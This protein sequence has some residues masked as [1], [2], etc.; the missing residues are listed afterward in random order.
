MSNASCENLL[1]PQ[2]PGCFDA[3]PYDSVQGCYNF[4]PRD[5]NNTIEVVAC[6]TEKHRPNLNSTLR[7]TVLECHGGKWQTGSVTGVDCK[8]EPKSAWRVVNRQ[9][10]KRGWWVNELTFYS[11]NNC[12]K[13]F[14]RTDMAAVF[15][16]GPA[17]S[18]SKPPD[19]FDGN[20]ASFWTAPCVSADA[21]DVCGCA[22]YEGLGWSR[23]QQKC[24]LGVQTNGYSEA[25][26][27]ANIAAGNLTVD[28]ESRRGCPAGAAS[29]GAYFSSPRE[30]GCVR[31]MQ[32]DAAGFISDAVELQ[33]WSME[34]WQN[35]KR[36][37]QL[38]GNVWHDLKVAE[39][40]QP[41]ALGYQLWTEVAGVNGPGSEGDRRTVQ[42][43]G[44]YS[45]A[46]I[47]CLR[48]SWSEIPPLACL[49]PDVPADEGLS[50]EEESLLRTATSGTDS[51]FQLAFFVLGLVLSLITMMV[52]FHLVRWW[53]RR[54]AWLRLVRQGAPVPQDD[55]DMEFQGIAAGQ[56]QKQQSKEKAGKSGFNVRKAAVPSVV[57]KKQK[58][59]DQQEREQQRQREAR[60]ARPK[61]FPPATRGVG[62]P[63]APPSPADGKRPLGRET[64]R[65]DQ[66]LGSPI[67]S[68]SNAFMNS[69]ASNGFANGSASN[70]FA[71]GG[72][73][74]IK[75]G[76]AMG[77]PVA[78]PAS[79][80]QFSS[81]Q[82]SQSQ[83]SSPLR[84]Q[85]E[86]ARPA[87]GQQFSS[88]PQP[89]SR[90][91]MMGPASS[92]Y[93][94]GPNSRSESFPPSSS[95][96]FPQR[97]QPQTV[98]S[99]TP[100]RSASHN[101]SPPAATPSPARSAT[102]GFGNAVGGTPAAMMRE[103]R[104]TWRSGTSRKYQTLGDDRYDA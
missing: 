58:E 22:T 81:P 76:K 46:V 68:A 8:A 43:I 97:A 87:S 34:G 38:R 9:A 24:V 72:S 7:S 15:D 6:K 11:D 50:S 85:S 57:F 29:I 90:S 95:N 5:V 27:A 92:R 2:L 66:V 71:A 54:S 84:S 102:E 83:F 33:A 61:A 67:G 18:S 39:G 23:A 10:T 12:R 16:A 3:Q 78:P 60:P 103:G 37:G 31:F 25:E 49:A 26:C 42:C 96:S 77:T 64:W 51:M 99:T 65:T 41:V 63:P 45:S 69:S 100:A 35:V 89:K 40:C 82:R 75:F 56:P 52:C 13:P 74:P 47:R 30:V 101:F 98:R 104:G 32:Y 80:H 88:P 55:D 94:E 28:S 21:F 36:W 17:G 59:R 1:L 91:D 14:S 70:G 19:A 79:A 53:C 4:W 44:G 93:L 62:A 73:P 48:G 86:I 20:V